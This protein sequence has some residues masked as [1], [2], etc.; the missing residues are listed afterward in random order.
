MIWGTFHPIMNTTSTSRTPS[1]QH[2]LFMLP[3]SATP[4]EQEH[5]VKAAKELSSRGYVYVASAHEH[6]MEDRDNVR[7]M[8]LRSDDL[9]RFGTVSTV[10]IVKDRAMIQAAEAAYPQAKVLVFEAVDSQQVVGYE[11]RTAKTELLLAA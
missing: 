9:P 4:A 8:P 5:V 3:H 10:M 2:F 7:F 6:T 11:Q 1:P